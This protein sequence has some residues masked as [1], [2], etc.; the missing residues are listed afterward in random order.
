MRGSKSYISLLIMQYVAKM[1][2]INNFDGFQTSV[3]ALIVFYIVFQLGTW[4]LRHL[5]WVT[6]WFPF[7]KVLH[8]IVFK[9]YITL[10]NTH[11][12][13]TGT[14][15]TISVIDTGLSAWTDAVMEIMQFGIDFLFAI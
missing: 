14:G 4:A 9:S 7:K 6:F 3:V 15:K 8:Q 2:E 5:G 10:D 11:T 1:M 13:K 12:E